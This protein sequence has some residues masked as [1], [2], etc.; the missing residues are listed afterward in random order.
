MCFSQ[1]KYVYK[2]QNGNAINGQIHDIQSNYRIFCGHIL[3]HVIYRQHMVIGNK[4]K[5]A[6]K[7]KMDKC[8]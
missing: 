3:P 6:S 8:G 4:T 1:A 7:I 2:Q 5:Q